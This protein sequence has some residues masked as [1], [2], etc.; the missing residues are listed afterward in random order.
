MLSLFED[1]RLKQLS[2]NVCLKVSPASGRFIT[3]ESSPSSKRT[4]AGCIVFLRPGVSSNAGHYKYLH[5][6]HKLDATVRPTYAEK[7]GGFHVGFEASLTLQIPR[8]P[9]I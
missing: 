9:N 2:K 5:Q 8:V 7:S 4:G 6:L 3:C 1:L